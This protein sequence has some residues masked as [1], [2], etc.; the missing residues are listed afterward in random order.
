MY[1]QA[2]PKRTE[3]TPEGEWPRL[4]GRGAIPEHA[5]NPLVRP[6]QGA[7]QD[8][9][10]AN[11]ASTHRAQLAGL[12]SPS[13]CCSLTHPRRWAWVGE[14]PCEFIHICDPPLDFHNIVTVR[15]VDEGLAGAWLNCWPA[16]RC[17]ASDRMDAEG[18]HYPSAPSGWSPKQRVIG[19]YGPHQ[20]APAGHK[21]HPA[22]RACAT[23]CRVVPAH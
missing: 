19:D 14:A 22:G 9:C 5:S 1:R 13:G 8:A 11:R 18:F 6:A 21:R 4:P 23:R 20:E 15:R 17:M 2:D 10:A 3:F 7:G 12:D 16:Y